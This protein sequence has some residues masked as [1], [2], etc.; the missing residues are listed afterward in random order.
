L[1]SGTTASVFG[2]G[3]AVQ[4]RKLMANTTNLGKDL[5]TNEKIGIPQEDRKRVIYILG[6]NGTGK[7]TLLDNIMLQDI[8]AGHGLCFL[9]PHG[10]AIKDI[11]I[12]IPSNREND[13]ILLNPLHTSMPFGLNPFACPDPSSD[14]QV[15]L[16]SGFVMHVFERVWG[17]G[18]E[19]PRLAQVLRNVTISLIEND[20]TMAEIPRLLQDSTFRSGV[21][22]N[23]KNDQ[24]RLFWQAYGNLKPSE[25]LER[26]D[27]T[28]NKIDAFLTQPLI[29]RIFG[30][31][32]DTID[33]RS[34]MDEGKIVLVELSP[35]LGDIATLI[36]SV[37][38]GKIL[39]A[40]YSRVDI[41]AK[42]RRLFSLVVDECQR[43]ATEDFVTLLSEGRKFSIAPVIA[44]QFRDQFSE[45]MKGASFNAYSSVIFQ[46]A[47]E[48]KDEVAA[49]FNT[50]PS[51]PDPIREE[52]LIPRQNVNAHLL[53]Y[54]HE[55]SKVTDFIMR[56][57]A[58]LELASKQ[59]PQPSDVFEDKLI[60][61]Y[62]DF[63]E[64]TRYRY[65]PVHIQ[66]GLLSLNNVL[67]DAMRY[68]KIT[69]EQQGWFRDACWQMAYFLGF[70]HYFDGEVIK[71][72]RRMD[73]TFE[74][75]I[76]H[77]A[78][79]LIF[80]LRV[81]NKMEKW[82]RDVIP[83][84]LSTD[85]LFLRLRMQKSGDVL[86]HHLQENHDHFLFWYFPYYNMPLKGEAGVGEIAHVGVYDHT[87]V[88]PLAQKLRDEEKKRY[89]NFVDSVAGVITA[90]TDVPIYKGSGRWIQKE[91]IRQT[92]Q[93]KQN[94][95]GNALTHLERYTAWVK[96]GNSE[97]AISTDPLPPENG[98]VLSDVVQATRHR[99]IAQGYLRPVSEVKDEL[100]ARQNGLAP[101]L[102]SKQR[103]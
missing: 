11:L 34:A 77:N 92:H 19:T 94:E 76:A 68:P 96:I 102:T 71:S 10:D 2:G 29:S 18:P 60:F 97:Y 23:V 58:P 42:D 12:R 75:P 35:R 81:E 82:P 83:Y 14:E 64:G 78:W 57:L 65:D 6:T 3:S 95:N 63:P 61:P 25:Q 39:D 1:F 69:P 50:T 4:R 70:P 33:W 73:K 27:S 49:L 99:N 103:L 36:G 5:Q 59:H 31:K 16:T 43:Y 41:P 40:A 93:D 100:R 38:I 62:V 13:V 9:D 47:A 98:V 101:Q 20:L 30:Q 53:N 24:V 51:A 74:S 52:M 84:R 80:A 91:G 48:D 79:A 46:I 66:K 15:A 54:G 85:R 72:F 87:E 32:R 22:R 7:T 45:K 88:Y 56:Y 8:E 17:V 86:F 67:Y 21:V 28:L 89:D 55:S 37:I 44:H 26:V 90:L